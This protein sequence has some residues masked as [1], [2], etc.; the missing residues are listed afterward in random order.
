MAAQGPVPVKII[1]VPERRRG[2]AAGDAFGKGA[3]CGRPFYR[4]DALG[5]GKGFETEDHREVLEKIRAIYPEVQPDERIH[6]SGPGGLLPD[7][8]V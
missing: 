1:D 6:G 8:G 7:S 5:A 2:M 4:N 3:A